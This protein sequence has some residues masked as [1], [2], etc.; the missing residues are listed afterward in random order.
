MQQMPLEKSVVQNISFI[1]ALVMIVF[2][3]FVL[4]HLIS[5]LVGGGTSKGQDRFY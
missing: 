1:F 4:C 3:L 5:V 2:K